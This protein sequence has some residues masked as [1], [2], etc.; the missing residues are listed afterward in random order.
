[1][2]KGNVA[3]FLAT[4]EL[5]PGI[6]GAMSAFNQTLHDELCKD[7]PS[8]CPTMLLAKGESH[9]SE[10]FSIDTADKTVSGPILAWMKKV[11]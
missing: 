1:M 11:K 10:V 7:G 5:D 3:L 4:A 6:N 9:M 8:R 2:K